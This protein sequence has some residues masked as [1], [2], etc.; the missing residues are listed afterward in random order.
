MLRS[1]TLCLISTK[2]KVTKMKMK[3]MKRTMKKLKAEVK[4]T[5]KTM[6]KT[7]V[8]MEKKAITGI[9]AIYQATEYVSANI[10]K[11]KARCEKSNGFISTFA[12]R[13]QFG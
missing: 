8:I 12:D 13:G 10:A 3:K 9:P 1:D 11:S 7:K 2:T 6:T 4:A 5:A